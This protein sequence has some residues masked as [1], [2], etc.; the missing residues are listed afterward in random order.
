MKPQQLKFT[1]IY[2][3]KA[4]YIFSLLMIL[5]CQSVFAQTAGKKKV[6]KEPVA[7][8]V[9]ILGNK[10]TGEDRSARIDMLLVEMGGYDDSM[11]VVIFYC[12]KVCYSGEFASH[13]RG[14]EQK[15]KNRNFD[16]S[17]III[18]FGGYKQIGQTELWVV[19][20]N[21]CLPKPKSNIKVEDV[22][23]KGSYKKIE[24]Y[25]CCDQIEPN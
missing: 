6:D 15:L 20:E 19:P 11:G 21:A 2:M 23:F 13:A 14:I 24:H 12:G 1:F 18:L 5:L 17:K 3:K 9:E 25:D 4:F 8:L 7:K 16:S 10:L 22:K